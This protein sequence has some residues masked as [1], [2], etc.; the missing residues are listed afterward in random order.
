MLNKVSLVMIFVSILLIGVLAFVVS[1]EEPKVIP[2]Y[3]YGSKVYVASG[4]YKGCKG[5]VIAYYVRSHSV[6]YDLESECPVKN[7][8]K[9][10]FIPLVNI[11]E[12]DLVEDAE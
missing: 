6:Q 11:D 1:K 2:K 5:T 4:F 10:T 12:E 8:R 7:S 9:V 3:S